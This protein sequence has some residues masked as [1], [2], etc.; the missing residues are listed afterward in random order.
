LSAINP[1]NV[2]WTGSNTTAAAPMQLGPKPVLRINSPPSIA[3]DK[4]IAL[5]VFGPDISTVNI[6][7]NMVLVNDQVDPNAD[8]CTPIQNSVAGKIALIERG[9]CTFA[10]K[11][12]TA[13]MSG[14]IGVVIYN[15]VPGAPVT[16]GGTDPAITIPSVMISDVDGAA[17][18]T[19]LN[20]AMIVNASITTDPNQLAGTDS[21]GRVLVYTPNPLQGGSSVSHWDTSCFPN[22][23]MEPAINNSITQTTD[24]TRYMFQDI[25]WFTGATDVTHGPAVTRLYPATPNPF[26]PNTAIKFEVASAGNVKLDVFDVQGRRVAGLYEGDLAAGPHVMVWNGRGLSGDVLPSGVYIARLLAGGETASQRL[27][28][29]K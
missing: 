8:A 23:L 12:L 19:E 1:S 6:S 7:G 17:I 26:N 21:Q 20:A 27:V 18:I 22:A 16:M 4:V 29:M 15:N 3:G 13:Q 5:A 10:S 11:V 28:L 24:L 9:T 14:A 2:V 25:G